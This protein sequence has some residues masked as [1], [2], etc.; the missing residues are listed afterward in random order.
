MKERVLFLLKFSIFWIFYFIVTK[1]IF[2]AYNYS[3]T[4]EL[5]FKDIF[6]IF[7]HGFKIDISTCGYFLIIPSLLIIF[8]VFFSKVNS[9][10]IIKIYSFS[11]IS[12]TSILTVFDMELYRNWGFRLDKTP[13][14]YISNP[15]EMMASVDLST[16]FLLTFT[17]VIIISIFI[18]FYNKFLK[19]EFKIAKSKKIS[20]S[21]LIFLFISLIIP[22]RGGFGVSTMNI[23]SVYFHKNIFAN[24]AAIN[25]VW[26]V[27]YSFTK[28]SGETNY[29]FFEQKKAQKIFDELYENDGSV[30]KIVDSETPNIIL[31]IL[32]SFSS[33]LIAPLGGIDGLTP[34]FNNLCKEGILFTNF[35]ASGDRSDKGIV[36]ILSGFP[37]QP[38]SSIIKF[39]NKTQNLP[40]ISKSLKEKGYKSSFYYGGDINFANMRSYFINGGFD[41]IIDKSDFRKNEINTKWG[42]HD[43]IVFNKLYEDILKSETPFFKAIFT[44]SSHEPFDVPLKS[45]FYDDD[46]E[47]RFLNSVH[48]TDKSLGE[49]INKLKQTELWNNSIIALVADH[50]SRLPYNTKYYEIDK[51]KIPFLL[52]GG[53]IK[54]K[55]SIISKISSQ[56]DIPKILLTQLDIPADEYLFSKNVF[57]NRPA[58][59]AFFCFNNGFGFV[60][61]KSQIV[62]DNVGEK[63]IIEKSKNLEEILEKGKAY[64]QIVETQF[65]KQ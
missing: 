45:E 61:S 28:T 64:L 52:T 22:I 27:I 41:E 5:P 25:L 31:I 24:H 60:S 46:E 35:F 53:A 56:T 59:F 10:R 18:L 58:S 57:T 7:F 16:I 39:A 50:G 3:F 19:T 26:N 6:L 62:Y 12:L 47:S 23:G 65:N 44:L 43:H 13:L 38:T 8:S 55:T 63:I 29:S 17:I 37:A 40:I 21:V 32:E 33:K 20:L 42:V 49:F 54:K 9:L 14:L 1:A 51:F 34:N 2:L 15:K 11:L 36:S 48:Y 30:I 4:K